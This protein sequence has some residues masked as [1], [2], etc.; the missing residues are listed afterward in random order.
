MHYC[1]L[2]KNSI[3]N[4]VISLQKMET[5]YAQSTLLLFIATISKTYC[6]VSYYV[7]VFFTNKVFFF[8]LLKMKKK[9]NLYQMC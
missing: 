1:I 2:F 6:F 7:N 5:L 3:E 4:W 9:S 8:P